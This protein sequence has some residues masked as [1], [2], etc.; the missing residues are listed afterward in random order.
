MVVWNVYSRMQGN[1]V[2][3]YFSD[4]DVMPFQSIFFLSFCPCPWPHLSCY[5]CSPTFFT[6]R[7]LPHFVWWAPPGGGGG[8]GVGGGGGGGGGGTTHSTSTDYVQSHILVIWKPLNTDIS[9]LMPC[10]T[11]WLTLSWFLQ[12]QQFCHTNT[13]P[14]W[15]ACGTQPHT[16][17]SHFIV[18]S[19]TSET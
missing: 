9:C 15:T 19:I 10:C 7:I 18:Q 13:E 17:S 8:G 14:T 11:K 6:L 16:C 5:P 1:R 3:L 4:Y 12:L 2:S